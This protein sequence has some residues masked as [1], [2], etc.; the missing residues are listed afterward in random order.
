MRWSNLWLPLL[1]VMCFGQPAPL[2]MAAREA[3]ARP[4]LLHAESTAAMLEPAARAL[5]LYRIAGAWLPLEPPRAIQ[6]YRES[7]AA[8]RQ[9]ATLRG[10]LEDAILNDLLSLSQADV[11]DLL[12]G[13]ESETQT[14]LYAAAINF[15]ILH[16]DYPAATRAFERAVASGILPTR[17]TAH[18]L[19]S[20]PAGAQ[21]ER[22]RV[23]TAAI[24]YYQ[25]HPDPQGFK[26]TLADLIARFYAQ[27][28]PALVLQAIDV[29]LKEAEEREKQHPGGGVS[30]GFGENN[31][32]FGSAY[33]L[34]LFAVAPALQQLEPQRAAALLAAHSGVAADL[35]RYPRGLPSL[36][37]IG[38]YPGKDALA[39]LPWKPYGLQLYNKIDNGSALSSMDMGL[40]FTIPRDLGTFGITGAFGFSTNP[41]DPEAA[42]LDPATPCPPDVAHRLELARSVPVS[43]KVPAICS[44][45]DGARCNYTDTFPRANVIQAI[46]TGCT[47]YSDPPAARAA[48]R[49]QLAL[50]T[51]MPAEERIGYLATAADLSF[52][53]DDRD[54]AGRAIQAGFA[55]AREVYAR[56]L[57]DPSIQNFPK[58]MWAAAEGYRRMIALG[59]NFSV[60]VTRKTIDEIPD[61]D[62]RELERVMMARAL[63]GVPV[64]RYISVGSN[65]TS[66]GDVEVTYDRF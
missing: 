59:V 65:G 19:G 29:V 5:L 36:D 25:M 21:A 10:S 26:W 54:G 48:L 1:A 50:L 47:Y 15:G 9:S 52:R 35:K 34:Q 51:Q 3:L 56:D 20:L 63:L 40:E 46:A 58:T 62:L 4:L 60:E 49:D 22:I 7:F 38:F 8:A 43:R 39:P 31:I 23:F 55:A 2:P 41:G 28:P 57:A 42:I 18:L 53:L 64:R 16:A 45:P 24:R 14:R 27:L 13:A 6:L 30:M 66:G 12:P 11:L 61:A 33:D 32:S 37:V 44:G 17:P